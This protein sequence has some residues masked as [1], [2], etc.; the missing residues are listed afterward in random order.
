VELDTQCA[1]SLPTRLFGELVDTQA[2]LDGPVT[3]HNF[4]PYIRWR[5]YKAANGL[6]NWLRTQIRSHLDSAKQIHK[7]S[8]IIDVAIHESDASLSLEEY[9]VCAKSFL[10]A[11]H[12]TTSTMLSW[13]YYY[14][15]Q[16]PEVLSKIREEHQRV[17]GP[18]GKDTE[19]IKQQILNSPSKLSELKYSM[20]CMKEVL[21]LYPPAATAR[22]GYDDKYERS[23]TPLI[24]VSPS[25]IVDWNTLRRDMC[26][27]ST[28]IGYIEIQSFGDPMPI[29]LT[30]NGLQREATC[31][32]HISPFPR[33]Q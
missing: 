23:Q 33:V 14:L 25:N 12:D 6:D 32:W 8:D 21:R 31:L 17:F 11:G 2:L 7:R 24:L 29:S 4:N 10:F 15:G 13:L 30:Q 19:G 5:R 20:Q 9:T 27:M 16:C 1:P 3:L 26:C 18:D 22:M 28:I